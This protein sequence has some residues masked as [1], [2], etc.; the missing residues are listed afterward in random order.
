MTSTPVR[1][2]RIRPRALL[3]VFAL[4]LAA[5][6]VGVG[7]A[8]AHTHSV[9]LSCKA[10]SVNLAKYQGHG[11]HVTVTEGSHTLVDKSFGSSY[12]NSWSVTSGKKVSVVVAATDDPNGSHG[13]SFTFNGTVPNCDCPPG[14]TVTVT[15]TSTATVTQTVTAPP[16]TQTVT[17]PP[18]TETTTATVTQPGSTVTLPGKTVTQK[19][20][21]P[22][23]K[24]TVFITETQDS[25]GV[26]TSRSTRLVNAPP[27]S[28]AFTGL[29]VAPY[30]LLAGMM[31]GVG[32]LILR[33]IRPARQH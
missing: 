33:K 2:V 9:D 32:Y 6:F 19:I 30:I 15:H 27:T 17:A 24:Q 3:A 13:W 23:G 14:S 26:V 22:G 25:H 21:V 10:L 11:N 16:V 12:V 1:R 28:L 5:L 4:A 29:D 7:T 8:E 31:I 20:K 18:V